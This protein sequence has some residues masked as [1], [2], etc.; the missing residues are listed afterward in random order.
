MVPKDL[1]TRNTRVIYKSSIS[2]HSK[3]MANFKNFCRQT[4]RERERE[5]ERQQRRR[6][7]ETERKRQTDKQT[8]GQT[9]RHTGQKLYFPDLLI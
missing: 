1:T 9:N 4:E 2:Y 3:V 8:E 5:R 6:D 7:R